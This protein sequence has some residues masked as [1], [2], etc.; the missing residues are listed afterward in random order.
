VN[1]HPLIAIDRITRIRFLKFS[2]IG[3]IALLVD[4]VVFQAV[5]SHSSASLYAVRA[6]SF[7]VATSAA[8]WLHRTFTFPDAENARA[9]LQWARFLAANL[10]GGSV[11]Y[12]SFVLM[13]ATVP[14]AAIY[15]V[16]ALAAGSLCGVAFNF[17]AYRLYVFRTNPGSSTLF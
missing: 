9:D 14:F 2:G 12:V 15:P 4:V 1:A 6:L 8:W 10:V 11:N 3:V 17:T 5:L 16:L 7:V 13:I